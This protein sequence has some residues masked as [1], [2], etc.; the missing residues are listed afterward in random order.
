M[1]AGDR[2]EVADAN[3]TNNNKTQCR[4]RRAKHGTVELCRCF[5]YVIYEL[6]ALALTCFLGASYS[7]RQTQPKSNRHMRFPVKNEYAEECLSSDCQVFC[8][9]V[10]PSLGSR[11]S[12]DATTTATERLPYKMFPGKLE[13]RWI[14]LSVLFSFLAF[15][16]GGTLFLGAL[17]PMLQTAQEKTNRNR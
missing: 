5:F 15:G 12:H 11:I 14:F 10:G 1:D 2:V 3:T 16:L 8:I 7:L 13:C 9:R 4:W 6:L 17:Y